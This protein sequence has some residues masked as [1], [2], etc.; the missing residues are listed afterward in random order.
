MN[1]AH[2]LSQAGCS[3]TS[4][5]LLLASFLSLLSLTGCVASEGDASIGNCGMRPP[6]TVIGHVG[7]FW[8][9][10]SETCGGGDG[11][12][13]RPFGQIAAALSSAQPGDTVV[14]GEANFSGNVTIPAGVNMVAMTAGTAVIKGSV[15]VLGGDDVTLRGFVIER[16][17]GPGL[18]ATGGRL[19]VEELSIR[20]AQ[21]DGGQTGHGIAVQGVDQ[22]V[23]TRTEITGCQGVGVLARGTG[24]VSIIEPIYLPSPRNA[25]GKFGIIE[26]IYQPRSRIAGNEMGGIAI[27]EPIY[28]P[29]GKPNL[30][31][32]STQVADNG[33]FGV[34]LWGA[35]ARVINSAIHTTRVTS[36]GAWA[37]GIMLAK[38]LESGD[39][40]AVQ[41]DARSVIA[42][43]ARTG[44][45][46]LAKA[47]LQVAGDIS[48]NAL[49]GVW[50]GA[51]SLVNVTGDASF[52]GNVLVGVAVANG[53]DLQLDGATIRGT[54]AQ[55][56]ETDGD[57]RDAGDG[58]G[59]FD[60]ARATIRNARLQNNARAGV[61]VHKAKQLE[62][63][64]PDVQISG[65][66]VTG[67]KYAVVVNGSP[68]P[69][70]KTS[71]RYEAESADE[72]DRGSA[73]SNTNTSTQS[74]PDDK[75]NANMAVKTEICD[76]STSCTPS[77]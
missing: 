10:Q 1:A 4:R 9:V 47:S 52:G 34:G 11:S 19:R 72:R 67:G 24:R 65:S 39:A 27:I 54:Q 63:G 66:L 38:G 77:F 50:A 58:I 53:A 3:W 14:L 43:N 62:D 68:A 45:A 70:F 55:T 7:R 37:D 61:L 64:A 16:P 2:R 28:S 44:V 33:G 48:N 21:S 57:D 20:D 31:L 59:V 69:S 42:N 26:P 17:A 73:G 32:E 5:A 36:K 56:L 76:E 74:S 13:E 18:T 8:Y 60:G 15:A 35:S 12:L 30:T 25:A 6:S 75:V 51:A 41:I 40:V 49:C 23:V 22:L 71:N 29:A 46:M